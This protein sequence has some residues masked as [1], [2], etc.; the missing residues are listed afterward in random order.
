MVAAAA[1]TT[2]TTTAQTKSNL[3]KR[4]RFVVED[5]PNQV[6]SIPFTTHF[7][8]SYLGD[9]SETLKH[10]RILE[11]QLIRDFEL[12]GNEVELVDDSHRLTSGGSI[13]AGELA[14]SERR[15]AG[16][17][18]GRRLVAVN[19]SGQEEQEE[20]SRRV[21]GEGDNYL[22]QF[23]QRDKEDKQRAGR[24]ARPLAEALAQSG[25]TLGQALRM[26]VEGEFWPCFRS[27]SC[28]QPAQ[29][30]PVCMSCP[31]QSRF[32][33]VRRKCAQRKCVSENQCR[34]AW[35]LLLSWAPPLSVAQTA[36]ENLIESQGAATGLGALGAAEAVGARACF[37]FWL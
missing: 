15:L 26:D 2:T 19:S 24:R 22:E 21:A 5:N 6:A 34:P 11:E 20:E 27:T 9:Q 7:V 37:W 31:S 33:S 8:T 32:G 3:I 17:P 35:L 23:I 28:S 29:F 12:M 36:A 13:S 4:N 30:A 14:P 25:S 1:A 16:G 18:D 10:E